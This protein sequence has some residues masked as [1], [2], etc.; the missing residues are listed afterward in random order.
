[1]GKAEVAKIDALLKGGGGKKGS[2]A[3]VKR[4]LQGA[5]DAALNT[6]SAGNEATAEMEKKREEIRAHIVIEPATAPGQCSGPDQ[7]RS[8]SS[9]HRAH[10]A[11]QPQ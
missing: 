8:S 5:A 3:G 9:Q 1:M 10:G 11:A 4:T 7:A 6:A 2:K